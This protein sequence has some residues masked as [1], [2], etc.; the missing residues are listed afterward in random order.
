[1]KLFDESDPSRYGLGEAAIFPGLSP[2]A[3]D[4]FFYKLMELQANVRLGKK[5][6]LSRFPSCSSASSSVSATLPPEG[7]PFIT[8]LRS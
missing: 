3:D 5:T 2:E 8:V 7:M 6:D 4:R 1:M